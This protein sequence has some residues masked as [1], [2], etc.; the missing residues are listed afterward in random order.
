MVK[1]NVTRGLATDL[2]LSRM[3]RENGFH[4]V[5]VHNGLIVR[6]GKL[7]RVREEK[8]IQEAMKDGAKKRRSSRKEGEEEVV[9]HDS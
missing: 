5:Q 7:E 1:V 6:H 9:D 2:V 8:W 3:L 4:I